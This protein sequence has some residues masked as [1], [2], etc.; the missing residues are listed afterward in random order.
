MDFIVFGEDDFGGNY[1]VQV[2]VAQWRPVFLFWGKGSPLTLDSTNRKKDCFWPL[3]VVTTK[4]SFFFFLWPIHSGSEVKN[5]PNTSQ[6]TY[7]HFQIEPPFVP[8]GCAS[9]HR[10]IRSLIGGIE[11]S[12]TH[13]VDQRSF[14]WD[15]P[16]GKYHE[17]MMCHIG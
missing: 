9:A 8:G 6:D 11:L 7:R 14:A 1:K 10:W 17:K 5:T 15:D 2:F 13:G 12:W 16:W 4:G 3:L